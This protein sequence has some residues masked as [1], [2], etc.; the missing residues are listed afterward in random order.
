MKLNKRGAEGSTLG[1]IVGIIVAV[2]LIIVVYFIISG[3]LG[4][5][6]EGTEALPGQLGAIYE[7]CK[8]VVSANNPDFCYNYKKLS[9]DEYIN[10]QDARIMDALN[11]T[12]YGTEAEAL[13]DSCNEAQIS[14]AQVKACSELTGM[15][16]A[17]KAKVTVGGKVCGNSGS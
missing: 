16:E 4:R 1:W 12:G 5:V 15:T 8:I 10:C 14:A 6:G 3:S 2:L 7:G 11:K 13:S 9:D 17:E